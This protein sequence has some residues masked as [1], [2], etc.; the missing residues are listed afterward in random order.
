MTKSTKKELCKGIL[1]ILGFI[2]LTGILFLISGGFCM[3]EC[4]A[5]KS[6]LVCIILGL[7]ISLIALFCCIPVESKSCECPRFSERT[8]ICSSKSKKAKNCCLC[9]YY[10]SDISGLIKNLKKDD[11]ICI[12]KETP[13]EKSFFDSLKDVN[14]KVYSYGSQIKIKISK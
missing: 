10:E 11:V 12:C 14:Y 6:I 1:L 8:L 13:I 3:M 9:H 7:L 4:C 2:L 5:I